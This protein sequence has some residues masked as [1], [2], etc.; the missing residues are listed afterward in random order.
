MNQE[1]PEAEEAP[2]T[3]S[4]PALKFLGELSIAFKLSQDVLP[5]WMK[6]VI[7]ERAHYMPEILKD[8]SESPIGKSFKELSAQN[9]SFLAFVAGVFWSAC[10][11]QFKVSVAK[12]IEEEEQ[13]PG[14]TP[15]SSGGNGNSAH[16]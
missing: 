9:P 15:P 7:A 16:G 3:L 11:L 6:D 10:F 8:F 12:A 5:D 4:N 13:K 2:S 14:P 1:Q